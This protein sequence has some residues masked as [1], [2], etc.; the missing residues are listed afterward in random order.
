[1]R[2]LDDEA[3]VEEAVA[4]LV[5]DRALVFRD[6]LDSQPDVARRL[7]PI[8]ARRKV[9]KCPTS[10]AFLAEARLSASFVRRLRTCWRGTSSTV[11]LTAF[12]STSGFSRNGFESRG[13]RGSGMKMNRIWGWANAFALALAAGIVSGT[14]QAEPWK[15]RDGVPNAEYFAKLNETGNQYIFCQSDR[16]ATP[17]RA[18]TDTL[19]D[20]MKT[21][22]GP[23]HFVIPEGASFARYSCVNGQAVYGERVCSGYLALLDFSASGAAGDLAAETV[24]LES[25]VRALYRYRLTHSVVFVHTVRSPWVAEAEKIADHYGIPSLDLTD[26]ADPKAREQTAAAFTRALFTYLPVPEKAVP[27][28]LPAHLHAAV[29]DRPWILA[30]EKELVK[31]TGCWKQGQA[32]PIRPF[33]HVLESAGADALL[34]VALPKSSSAG[35]IDVAGSDTPAVEYSVDGGAWRTVPPPAAG[36]AYAQRWI[37]CF[38]GLDRTADHVL[39]LRPVGGTG[40]LRLA[41]ITVNGERVDDYRGFTTLQR[42]DAVYAGMGRPVTA[43]LAPDRF[44]HIPNTMKK[45]R[46]GGKLKMLWLGDSIIGCTMSSKIDLLLK[47][48]FPKCELQTVASIRSSTGCAWYRQENR[49]EEWVLAKNP[50][51]VVI[52]GI[53]NGKAEYVR[54]V[55]RQIRARR[56]EMEILLLTPVFGRMLVAADAEEPW[57]EEVDFS[58][59]NY[60][61]GL[62]RVAAEEKCAFFDMTGPWGRY[63]R[64]AGVTPGWFWGDSVHANERG[65]QIIGRLLELWFRSSE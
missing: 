37:T 51:T 3:L 53:S 35:F 48:V 32:S 64:D 36:S 6:L 33:R 55:V 24:A 38:E 31:K 4:N 7:L 8:I 14:V 20:T 22:V 15:L 54:E 34:E 2:G 29:D 21:H 25:H 13:S 47:R 60:R 65:C 11:R 45:L 28:K 40:L 1:M 43:K 26:V 10:A 41:G 49:V 61:A 52:G 17:W 16:G 58:T 50:D 9:V 30:Y 56:P 18:M 23:Q 44:R 12:R 59:D 19:R 46:E 27:R 5:E 63:V 62:A 39:R 57:T 42:I